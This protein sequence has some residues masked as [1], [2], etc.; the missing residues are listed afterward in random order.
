[1]F[2]MEKSPSTSK[3]VR[4]R[5][6]VAE[7]VVY[8]PR[9]KPELLGGCHGGHGGHG[10]WGMGGGDDLELSIGFSGVARN[11]TGSPQFR[12]HDSVLLFGGDVP[13]IQLLR[14]PL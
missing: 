13:I 10:G 7:E 3:V 9:L 8:L 4:G 14:I 12:L 11:P 2:P 5:S 6:S 1:M